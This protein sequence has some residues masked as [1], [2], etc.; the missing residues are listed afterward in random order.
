MSELKFK[1][2]LLS[3]VILNVKSASEGNQ[4]TLDFIPGNNFLGIVASSLYYNGKDND[5]LTLEESFDYFHS[6][7]VRFGDA[8]PAAPCEA[9]NIRSLRVP[10]T[11]YFEK[12]GKASNQCYI[13]HC[14]SRE[15]DKRDNTQPKQLKQCRNGFYSFTGGIGYPAKIEKE[16]AIKSAYDKENRRS[17]DRAMYG[18]ESLDK[19]QVFYFS[20]ETADSK[21]DERI[22]KALVGK[23]HIG[24]SRTAQYG[25]IEISQYDYD[26]ITKSGECIS[27]GKE[28]YV[29]VYADSR[30]IFLDNDG[31]PT[32]RPTS[33]QLGL[34]KGG[35]IDWGKSQIRTFQYAPWNFKRKA[36]DTDRCGIEKGS[37][38]V[39]AC[40][41]CPEQAQYVGSYCNEGFGRVIYNPDFLSPAADANNGEAKFKIMDEP[42][43]KKI[44][45]NHSEDIQDNDLLKYL[46]KKQKYRDQEIEIYEIVNEFV[47]NNKDKFKKEAFASQWG[48]I[49]SYAMQST[50][51]EGLKKALLEDDKGYLMHGVAKDK[52]EGGGRLHAFEKFVVRH[53]R[54]NIREILINLASQMAKECRKEK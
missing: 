3:D 35:E 41:N 9:E 28:K 40:D 44:E 7:K 34:P 50:S 45:N 15:I 33:E 36:F 19:N 22:I 38:F 16:F 10:A 25:Q 37:V 14:Y 2:T 20:V 32:F 27:I 39:V 21:Y 29:T 6:S 47:D 54:E 13:H 31:M 8:H 12:G 26:Q 46:D 11:M 1:C 52:W 48:A 18:Y 43:E 51:N 53:E 49:R 42:K 4:Q 17:K 5:R 30:L 23:K 24:R